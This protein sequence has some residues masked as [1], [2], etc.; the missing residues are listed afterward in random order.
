MRQS[1]SILVLAERALHEQFCPQQ[2]ALEAEKL[3][4]L[5]GSTRSRLPR[6]LS[7]I[8][9]RAQKQDINGQD[10]LAALEAVLTPTYPTPLIETVAQICVHLAS[11]TGQEELAGQL[12][13]AI[14]N[15]LDER[16]DQVGLSLA[17][18]HYQQ[19]RHCFPP[20]SP[21]YGMAQVNEGNA[22]LRLATLGITP[23]EHTTGGG[24]LTHQGPPLLSS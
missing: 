17:V 14:A 3:L 12:H 7:N 22:R 24:G 21:D 13:F 16:H 8:L 19:A 2:L 9:P 20:E 15:V 6:F 18:Q 10:I 5:D 23:V 1:N 4:A 11:R